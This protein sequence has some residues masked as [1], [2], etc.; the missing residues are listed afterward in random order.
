MIFCG[1]KPENK[2]LGSPSGYEAQHLGASM[3]GRHLSSEDRR[4]LARLTKI[5]TQ[6]IVQVVVQSRLGEKAFTK[7]KTPAQGSEWFNLGI[8]DIHEIQQET[9]RG[10]GGHLPDV[11]KPLVVEI[12]LRTP[13]SDS[14]VLEFWTLTILD[15]CDS[16]P[17]RINPTI[18]NRMTVLLKSLLA[19][20]RITPAYKLAFRQ[21][22]DSF[23]ICY[24]VYLGD[25]NYECL[26]ENPIQARL[27]QVTT[28]ESTLLLCVSYRTQITI[29]PPSRSPAHDAI[30]LKSDHFKPE[31]SPRHCRRV[32]D[33]GNDSSEATQASDDSQDAARLFTASPLDQPS[34]PR[35]RTSSDSSCR[36]YAQQQQQQQPERKVSVAFVDAKPPKP[37]DF[38]LPDIPF[39]NL[40]TSTVEVQLE[41]KVEKC[42]GA[43]HQPSHTTQDHNA[44]ER[45]GAVSG[46]TGGI[47]QHEAA[48]KTLMTTSDGSHKSTTSAHLKEE[49]DFVMVELKTPFAG[50][51]DTGNDLGAFYR[52]CQSAPPLRMFADT[53]EDEISDLTEQLLTFEA[54]MDEYNELVKSLH[55]ENSPNNS[56]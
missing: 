37:D 38:I 17:S 22:P 36:G 34:T 35:S 20:T 50:T 55:S 4:E 5:L 32:A 25:P 42:E 51:Y 7:S 24:R 13:E 12:L 19:V 15:A 3:S 11:G 9:K 33:R 52:E 48:E 29:A 43:A 6:K 1:C 18:Y 8:E 54:N 46:A 40:L 28:P 47:P 21:G 44:Q 10:L 31:V 41:K 53:P 30:M 16:S 56:D 39:S 23:I 45:G 49:A 27:G 2:H 14:L 26:G